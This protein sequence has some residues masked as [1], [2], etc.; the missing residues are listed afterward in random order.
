MRRSNSVKLYVAIAVTLITLGGM[1][2]CSDTTDADGAKPAPKALND[3]QLQ[4][5]ASFTGGEVG[6]VDKNLEAVKIGFINVDGGVPAFPESTKAEEVAAA[7]INDHLGG[8]G[9]HP[10]E[11]V[12]CN[13]VQG[14]EDAQKC[15]QQF[16]NDPSILSV[17]LGMTVLGTGPIY[18]TIGTKKNVI[19]LG[20]FS[21][22]DL[23]V[24]GVNYYS[25]AAFSAGPGMALYAKETLKASTMA[26][27]FDQTDPGAAG[28]AQLVIGLSKAL[29]IKA[30]SVPVTNASEWSTAL[31]SAG[32]QTA[33]AVAVMGNTS[34][35]VPMAQAVQ[36]LAIT[37]PVLTFGFC[38]DNSVAEALGEFPE[39]TYFQPTKSPFGVDDADVKLYNAVME[40]YAPDANQSGGANGTFQGLVS[41]VRAMNE[42]GYDNLSVEAIN[43]AY[44]GFTGPVFL[45]PQ[46]IACGQYASQGAQSLCTTVA[47]P[48]QFTGGK[49]VDPTDGAGLD[50]KGIVL[51]GLGR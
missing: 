34:V 47:F 12:Q 10:I 8:V 45:G 43:K 25:A 19:G 14:D 48:V 50:T 4:L 11:I 42:V 38:Q 39:W 9:G 20:T 2:A 15:A 5:A 30:T 37:S 3:A 29:G 32:A 49:W 13:I 36:Q 33:D 28:S 16:A 21:P 46:E 44:S 17:Q 24:P 27:V 1:T 40:S 23:D 22:A 35:C 7:F 41:L 26:I 18:S 6:A 51:A 31:V